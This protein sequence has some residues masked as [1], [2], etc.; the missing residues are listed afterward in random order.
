[1]ESI[2]KL[3]HKFIVDRSTAKYSPKTT[4]AYKKFFSYFLPRFQGKQLTYDN[5]SEFQ[6][7]K[8]YKK[9]STFNSD[10]KN[11]TAFVNWLEKHKHISQDENFTKRLDK[12]PTE[13]RQNIPDRETMG[14]IITQI[15]NKTY[16]CHSRIDKAEVD[17]EY[18]PA[19]KLL[20]NTGIRSGA[21]ETIKGTD[22]HATENKPT[23]SIKNKGDK[24]SAR[25]TLP[26]PP[27]CLEDMRKRALRHDNL[28]F[29]FS[30]PANY[31]ATMNTLLK[32]ATRSLG[33][34]K[35]TTHYFRHSY[36]THLANETSAKI[37]DIKELLCHKNLS[38]TMTYVH[39]DINHLS[40]VVRDSIGI[41]CPESLKPNEFN[42]AIINK[43]LALGF[44]KREVSW[45]SGQ[46]TI[47]SKKLT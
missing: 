24:L 45:E 23:F 20:F 25:H 3:A 14:K 47:K 12:L 33:I 29:K 36:A 6:A 46:I 31:Q 2:E 5:W 10:I 30:S 38:T 16:D 22:I 44:E 13:R 28:A 1:M 39:E 42:D 43:I 40:E 21:I 32:E 17:N 19:L 41:E 35:V 26:I 7:N 18:L 9:S 15:Q 37:Q 8:I 11:I 27:Q 4:I 34:T